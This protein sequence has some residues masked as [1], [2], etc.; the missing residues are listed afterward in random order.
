LAYAEMDARKRREVHPSQSSDH[1]NRRQKTKESTFASRNQGEEKCLTKI[2]ER[3]SRG[4]DRKFLVRVKK[5][6]SITAWGSRQNNVKK[7][8]RSAVEK[9][10]KNLKKGSRIPGMDY[11][12]GQKKGISQLKK[13][14]IKKTGN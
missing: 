9:G 13:A 1:K 14:G 6:R 11:L 8:R 2:N 5:R 4:G 3:R 7:G 10:G 12:G